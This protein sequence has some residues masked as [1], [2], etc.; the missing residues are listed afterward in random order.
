MADSTNNNAPQSAAGDSF[1]RYIEAM[2]LDT[3]G[4]LK[5][6][7]V[8]LQ[9]I[10]N[11]DGILI[12]QSSLRDLAQQESQAKS[13]QQSLQQKSTETPESGQQFGE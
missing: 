3:E 7:N 12:S 6:I 9:S 5:S 10:T 1:A 2:S 13:N 8:R 11:N 4:T